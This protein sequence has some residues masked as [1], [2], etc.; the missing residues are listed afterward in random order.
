MLEGEWLAGVSASPRG[1]TNEGGGTVVG[2]E[3]RMTDRLIH[4]WLDHR[5]AE[6]GVEIR[7]QGGDWVDSR[8][9]GSGGERT[10]EERGRERQET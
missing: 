9:Q 5:G 8:R 1:S 3:P 2:D 4:W 6:K 7:R 10:G